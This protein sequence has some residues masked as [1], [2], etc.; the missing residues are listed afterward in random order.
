MAK[1]ADLEPAVPA[2]LVPAAPAKPEAA[3]PAE[4][5]PAPPA[6]RTP[7]P[8]VP[9]PGAPAGPTRHRAL[10]PVTGVLSS[11]GAVDPVLG[12][13]VGQV[14]QSVDD[15]V[16][17]PVGGLVETVTDELAEAVAQIPPLS[18]LPTLPELPG[19]PS[20]P[21]LPGLPTVPVQTL[22]APVTPPDAPGRS[23]G[24]GLSSTSTEKR[25]G[26]ASDSAAAGVTY[27]PQSGEARSAGHASAHI[28]GR[29]AA[30]AGYAPAR[31]APGGDPNG[32]LSNRSAV[33]NG[34]SRHGDAHA[35]TLG[36]RV[37]LSLL[38]GAAVPGDADATRERHRDIPVSPA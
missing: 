31:Q 35:V 24:A 2:E 32:A 7:V 15:G 6:S 12:P 29:R 1:P 26:T 10:H 17:R 8:G 4:P 25:S 28:D 21:T 18:S 9:V 37:P 3:T 20:V 23:V 19:G 36:R 11:P 34:T 16:L 33:D 22:P 38:L 27:G 14:A 5:K 13:L 30:D